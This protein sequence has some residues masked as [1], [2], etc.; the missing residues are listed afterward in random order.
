MTIS[1]GT[2]VFPVKLTYF[3]NCETMT[4]MGRIPAM[5]LAAMLFTASLSVRAQNIGLYE[6]TPKIRTESWLNGHIPPKSEFTYI[7]FVHTSSIPCINSIR[8]IAGFA[9]RA[10]RIGIVI[11]TKESE[12]NLDEWVGKY[13]SGNSGVIF[14]SGDIFDRFGVNYAPFGVIVDSHRRALWFGNPR[15][16]TF[17]RLVEI[18]E[19]KR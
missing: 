1:R 3:R 19:Q 16:L 14:E 17:E 15:Q 7:G 12:K 4:A 10:G 8:K 5:M 18:M 9:E 6:R 11:V 2:I 13:A